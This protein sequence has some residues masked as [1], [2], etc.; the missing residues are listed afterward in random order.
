[1]LESGCNICSVLGKLQPLYTHLPPTLIAVSH[2]V[3][4]HCQ[5]KL[6][7]LS[8]HQCSGQCL[9]GQT[10]DSFVTR[11]SLL[12]ELLCFS[13]FYLEPVRLLIALLLLKERLKSWREPPVLVFFLVVILQWS[14]AHTLR[15]QRGTNCVQFWGS[16]GRSPELTPQI[17]TFHKLGK[18]YEMQ[19]R[20]RPFQ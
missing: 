15:L 8:Q 20:F 13:L 19:F 17:R 2:T 14:R 4:L 3:V 12:V 11:C 6:W 7:F 1:M 16:S 5:C 9:A 10:A 18:G